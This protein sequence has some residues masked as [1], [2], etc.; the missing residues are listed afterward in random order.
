MGLRTAE[1]SVSIPHLDEIKLKIYLDAYKVRGLYQKQNLLEH[2]M[3]EL[4][5][6]RSS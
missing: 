5:L 1:L 2:F 6:S 4:Q 3:E